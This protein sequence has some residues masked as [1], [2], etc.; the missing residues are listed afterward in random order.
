M[1]ELLILLEMIMVAKLKKNP[2]LRCRLRVKYDVW[3]LF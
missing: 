2:C 1:K 3:D